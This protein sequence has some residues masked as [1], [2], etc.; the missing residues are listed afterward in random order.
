MHLIFRMVHGITVVYHTVHQKE[1]NMHTRFTGEKIDTRHLAIVS[2]EN[3]DEWIGK[4][5]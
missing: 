3:I 1:F 4:G 5:L 2:E